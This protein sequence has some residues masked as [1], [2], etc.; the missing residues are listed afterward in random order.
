MTS[1]R[2][3]VPERA[4]PSLVRRG[5]V[6]LRAANPRAL[7]LSLEGALADASEMTQPLNDLLWRTHLPRWKQL[8]G[9][10]ARAEND[11]YQE[12]RV[13]AESKQ[14]AGAEVRALLAFAFD[15]EPYADALLREARGFGD[16]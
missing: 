9:D 4:Q 6:P 13:W 1:P 2:V 15:A 16:K 11:A 5:Q 14:K 8:R 3:H 7:I 12:V 10:L